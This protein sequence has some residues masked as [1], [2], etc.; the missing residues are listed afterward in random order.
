MN[1][2]VKTGC[3]TCTGRP[4][5]EE[6]SR[7]ILIEN[8]FYGIQVFR[9]VADGVQCFLGTLRSPC[10]RQE[11]Q[12]DF[13]LSIGTD[14]QRLQ[15]DEDILTAAMQV[16]GSFIRHIRAHDKRGHGF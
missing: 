6:H 7:R 2:G 13:F 3:L 15:A 16:E 4:G 11:A 5:I 9:D 10:L 14:W 1:L 12:I 8:G